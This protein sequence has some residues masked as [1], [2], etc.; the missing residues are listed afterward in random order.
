MRTVEPVSSATA[1]VVF[2]LFVSIVF[3]ICRGPWDPLVKGIINIIFPKF[4]LN[5]SSNF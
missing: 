4:Y 1:R 2:A 5:F 3:G